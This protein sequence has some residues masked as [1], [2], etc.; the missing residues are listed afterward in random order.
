MK[1]NL[2]AAILL[3]GKVLFECVVG[4]LTIRSGQRQIVVGHCPHLTHNQCDA[5]SGNDPDPNN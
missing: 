2:A 5:N 3:W 4:N 1:D